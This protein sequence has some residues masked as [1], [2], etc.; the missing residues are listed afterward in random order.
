[1]CEHATRDRLRSMSS[2]AKPEDQHPEPA[3]RPLL[4]LI[5]DDGSQAAAT[6]TAMGLRI[7]GRTHGTAILLHAEQDPAEHDRWE[8]HLV[9]AAEYA[10]A[11]ATT[12]TMIQR[13]DPAD[14]ILRV[15]T[16]ESA[17]L[18]CVGA[19]GED[20]HRRSVS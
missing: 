11:H 13:G 6:S 4:V 15:A 20:H 17:D 9:N 12:R 1:M 3:G 5:A 16:A 8:R 14:V 19:A 2:A 18:I 10:P 7:A